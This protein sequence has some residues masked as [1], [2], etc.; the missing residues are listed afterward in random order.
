MP[1]E[2]KKFINPLL[3]PSQT[4]DARPAQQSQ[5]DIV[6]EPVEEPSRGASSR[7]SETRLEP[8]SKAE[9][10]Q[11]GSTQPSAAS[12]EPVGRQ[13]RSTENDSGK[14]LPVEEI[15]AS[16]R[17]SARRGSTSAATPAKTESQGRAASRSRDASTNIDAALYTRNNFSAEPIDF[18]SEDSAFEETYATYNPT[19]SSEDSR[20]AARRRRS[21]QPFETTHERITL[22]MDKQLKQRFEALAYQRELPKTAL[23]NEAVSALLEKYEAH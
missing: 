11:T 4:T 13:T 7:N 19:A 15:P 6:D 16:A 2:T 22:W 3:R 17:P 20:A 1:K 23:I 21:L 14:T 5:P 8:A 12:S 9:P 10:T 18:S